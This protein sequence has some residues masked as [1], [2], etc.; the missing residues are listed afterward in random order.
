MASG[1]PVKPSQQAIR[2][3]RSPRLRSWVSTECQNFAPSVSAIQQPSA[4]LRPSTSTP[5]T[6]CALL[7]VTWSGRPFS[8]CGAPDDTRRDERPSAPGS[9]GLL[10][11]GPWPCRA[12]ARRDC[13]EVARREPPPRRPRRCRPADGAAARA[14]R[15]PHRGGAGAACAG[16]R[17]GPRG[18]AACPGRLRRRRP[19][20]SSPCTARAPPRRTVWQRCSRPPTP[21]GSLLLAPASHDSTWDIISGGWGPDARCIDH[22]LARV[23]DTDSV[24]TTRLAVSGFSDG[25]S[26]ARRWDPPTPTCSP[27][28]SRSR[29]PMSSRSRRASSPRR[30]GS[31]P[32][33]VSLPRSCRHG[34]PDRRTSRRIV[35]RLW[36]PTSRYRCGSSTTRT[37][38]P[39]PS[40]RTPC[41][42]WWSRTGRG[43]RSSG[44]VRS[45]VKSA[46]GARNRHRHPGPGTP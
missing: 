1:S 7:M 38:C 20:W 14:R 43:P 35:A 3:S 37:S 27:M 29:S 12:D 42:G 8:G 22:A 19:A 5:M 24:E 36:R 45:G 16:P 30:P 31:A 34:S 11:A 23:F 41:A 13:R 10:R 4:C 15:R 17:P 33:R 32:Q 40:P 18:P 46:G 44:Q 26:Y 21:T 9:A 28:S 2:T 25:A 6:R 39:W